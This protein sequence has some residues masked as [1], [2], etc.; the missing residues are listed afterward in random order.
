MLTMM[1]LPDRKRFL[2]LVSQSRGDV[3][4]HLPDNS[5]LSLKQDPTAQ[6]LLQVM[7]PGQDGLQITLTNPTDTTAFMRYML[8]AT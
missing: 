8:E 6:R 7:D 4:L 1:Y 2:Q 3:V 5:R